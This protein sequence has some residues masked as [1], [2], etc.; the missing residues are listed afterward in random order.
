MRAIAALLLATLLGGCGKGDPATNQAKPKAV[1]NVIAPI[2]SS[3]PANAADDAPPAPQPVAKAKPLVSRETS[4]TLP[5]PPDYRAIGTEP[6]WGVTLRGSTVLLERPDHP[7]LRFSVH[8]QSDDRA[9]RLV[10][11]G[12]TLTATEGPCSDGM[13]EAI[14]SDRVQIAFADGT[15]KGCGGMREDGP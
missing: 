13:S 10:G 7:P 11:D 2:N 12:F 8:D 15:L 1:A 3:I 5:S 4:K 14:W 6:F 9:I